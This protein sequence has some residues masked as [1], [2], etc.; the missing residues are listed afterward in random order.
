MG[1]KTPVRI[2]IV[3][4]LKCMRKPGRIFSLVWR[5]QKNFCIAQNVR[6]LKMFPKAEKRIDKLTK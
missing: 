6:E 5:N 2:E 1:T 3:R 4:N